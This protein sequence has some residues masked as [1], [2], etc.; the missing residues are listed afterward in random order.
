M[1]WPFISFDY[2]FHMTACFF[3]KPNLYSDYRSETNAG[4]LHVYKPQSAYKA[5][6]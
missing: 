5:P 6:K 4:H 1:P 3:F 2:E